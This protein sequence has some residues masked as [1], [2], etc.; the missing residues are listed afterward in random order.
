MPSANLAPAKP[1]RTVVERIIA[2][3]GQAGVARGNPGCPRRPWSCCRSHPRPR[4]C[5]PGRSYC[6]KA[7]RR[8]SGNPRTGK[9]TTRGRHWPGRRWQF[10]PGCADCWSSCKLGIL[11]LR[12][13]VW[14]VAGDARQ[15]IGGVRHQPIHFGGTLQSSSHHALGLGKGV[16]KFATLTPFTCAS[17]LYAR[18]A[19]PKFRE[20]FPVALP[21]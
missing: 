16:Q 11:P 18:F 1:P 2:V 4:H 9:R 12:M 5:R 21:P 15:G 10:S 14:P 8:Q 20:R 17:T 7:G 3:H 6:S 13:L 19:P